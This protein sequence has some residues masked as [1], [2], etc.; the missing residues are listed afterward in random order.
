MMKQ[1]IIDT[2][3]SK[4]E[5][6]SGYGYVLPEIQYEIIANELNAKIEQEKYDTLKEFVEYVRN[7]THFLPVVIDVLLS[8]MEHFIKEREK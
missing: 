5:Y 6:I 8:Q 1:K 4:Q 7:N 2:I 3:K